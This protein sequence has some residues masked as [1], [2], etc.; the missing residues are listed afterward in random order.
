M[1]QYFLG[2]ITRN[3]PEYI[4]VGVVAREGEQTEVRIISPKLVPLHYVPGRNGYLIVTELKH[5]FREVRKEQGKMLRFEKIDPIG[6]EDTLED[7]ANRL[8]EKYVLPYYDT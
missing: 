2:K 7:Q 3:P 1:R 5:F 6:D 8:F 4:P